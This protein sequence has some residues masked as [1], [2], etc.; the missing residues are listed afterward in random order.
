MKKRLQ[1]KALLFLAV[2]L[3]VSCTTKQPMYTVKTFET[4]QG[5]GY[6]IFENEKLVI[7]QA[8]VPSIQKQESFKNERDALKI[9]AF[10]IEK[11]KQHK[12]PSLTIAEVKNNIS[13]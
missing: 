10:V 4:E 6:S 7:R 13:L 12:T 9:G 2:I 5:W 11:L 8:Y 1:F 3:V